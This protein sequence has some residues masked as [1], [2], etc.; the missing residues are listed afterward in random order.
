MGL[1]L[2]TRLTMVWVMVSYML[3]VGYMF[4]KEKVMWPLACLVVLLFLVPWLI[5]NY[6]LTGNIMGTNAYVVGVNSSDYPGSSVYRTYVSLPP[7]TI[8]NNAAKFFRD[9]VRYYSTHF[10]V[11]TGGSIA[12]L[13]FIVGLMHPFKRIRAQ[14][15][16]WWLAGAVILL[17]MGGSLAKP[18]PEMVDEFNQLAVLFPAM[19]IFGGAFF[20]VLLDRITNYLPLVRYTIIS[21]YI[22]ANAGAFI[23]TL[24]PPREPLYRYPPYFPPILQYMSQWFDEKEVIASD[25]PWAT[26]WYTQRT[27]IWLPHK[28][29]DFYRI[30]DFVQPIVSMIFTPQTSNL[31]FLDIEKGEFMEWKMMIRREGLPQG[32][33]L[34]HPSRLPPN[35]DEYMIIADRVRWDVQNP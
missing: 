30:N 20:F 27:S 1:M 22:I 18:S 32:F 19:V 2:L 29:D 13:F 25:I 23:M 14:A 3:V 8:W 31:G 35:R 28:L 10:F 15:L 26:A 21:A 12:V 6:D 16:R 9:G 11:L 7:T 24:L 33:P 5:R 17:A 4:R 34:Q